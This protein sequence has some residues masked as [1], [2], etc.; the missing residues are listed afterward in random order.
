M[1]ERKTQA[2]VHC[3]SSSTSLLKASRAEFCQQYILVAA[4]TCLEIFRVVI[5]ARRLV[6]G[7]KRL[8]AEL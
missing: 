2:R 4:E 8:N 1:E 7:Q 6:S 3:L 5:G